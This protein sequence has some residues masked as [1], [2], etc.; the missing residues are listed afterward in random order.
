MNNA[1]GAAWNLGN[2]AML[3]NINVVDWL[4]YQPIIGCVIGSIQTSAPETY[5]EVVHMDKAVDW[6]R[7]RHRHQITSLRKSILPVIARKI[8]AVRYSLSL[9]MCSSK[10]KWLIISLAR[11]DKS[12]MKS[13]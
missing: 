3:L 7:A 9:T 13:V 1:A 8:K 12:L 4:V 10:P 5:V 2:S 11:L 6:R